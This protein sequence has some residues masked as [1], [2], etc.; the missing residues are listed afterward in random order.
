M[1][2]P[3]CHVF[4]RVRGIGYCCALLPLLQWARSGLGSYGERENRCVAATFFLQF[5]LQLK[6][7]RRAFFEDGEAMGSLVELIRGPRSLQI[8]YQALFCQWILTF[9]SAIAT[10]LQLYYYRV[11]A[12]VLQ[13]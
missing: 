5:F 2:F 7:F 1:P 3:S 9:D 10:E 11:D 8:Q 6:A 13:A 12:R 4:T